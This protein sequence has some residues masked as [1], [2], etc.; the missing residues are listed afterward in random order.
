MDK[1][2][3]SSEKIFDND[4]ENTKTIEK[5]SQIRISDLSRILH[6]HCCSKF[7]I[8]QYPNVKCYKCTVKHWKKMIE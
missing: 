4:N 3:T 2:N 1:S 6:L 7:I 8:H 5:L